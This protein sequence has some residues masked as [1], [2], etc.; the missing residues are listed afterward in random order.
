[1][2]RL[3]LVTETKKSTEHAAECNN[4]SSQISLK[5]IKEHKDAVLFSA[6][7]LELEEKVVVNQ[8]RSAQIRNG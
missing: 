7:R 6:M 3:F 8:Q 5:Q 4:Q 1:M 2:M